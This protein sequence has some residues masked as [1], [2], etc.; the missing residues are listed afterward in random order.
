VTVFLVEQ[1]AKKALENSDVGYVMDMGRITFEG[2][3]SDLLQEEVVRL[4]YL[5][6]IKG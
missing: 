5:G 1:N 4:S 3:S 6:G 2:N